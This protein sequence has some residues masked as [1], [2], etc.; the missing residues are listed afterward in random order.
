MTLYRCW[1]ASCATDKA[2]RL[3]FD[4]DASEPVCPRCGADARQ[5]RTANVV[6]E[7]AV[8]HFEP[9]SPR[10]GIG[11]GETACKPGYARHRI[12][13]HATSDPRVVNCAECRKTEVF[14]TEAARWGETI[15]V[16][17]E[18]DFA[19]TVDTEAKTIR[20]DTPEVAEA[21]PERPP[22]E[23]PKARRRG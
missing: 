9:P 12:A 14:R 20:T 22:E 16:A 6:I 1:N 4:F 15:A 11:I 18:A 13:R 10:D 23:R 2:G 19:V 5:P 8:I 17:P 21:P 7:L 3:G